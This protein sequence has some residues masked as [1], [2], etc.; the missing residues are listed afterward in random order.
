MHVDS[1]PSLGGRSRCANQRRVRR[2]RRAARC[3]PGQATPRAGAR[4][5]FMGCRLIYARPRRAAQEYD[6]AG[7]PQRKAPTAALPTPPGVAEQSAVKPS[8]VPRAATAPG[9]GQHLHRP[10]HRPLSA[11]AKA[12]RTRTFTKRLPAPAGND[13][14]GQPPSQ[15][16]PNGIRAPRG[17]RSPIYGHSPF[18]LPTRAR[19]MPR[20]RGPSA[21]HGRIN[22]RLRRPAR[23]PAR[24]T[25]PAM[26]CGTTPPASPAGPR[27]PPQPPAAVD[28]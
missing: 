26:P 12:R 7:A 11:S 22:Q 16:P 3:A 28:P 24:R 27:R 20:C 21:A 19:R 14:R 1:S 10:R 2:G 23:R 9:T 18:P 8:P 4:A 15:T 13:R 17:P 6:R 25:V 5:R